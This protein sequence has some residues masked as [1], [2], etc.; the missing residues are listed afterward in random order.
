MG[1][2]GTRAWYG[3]E[4]REVRKRLRRR[5]RQQERLWLLRR[6]PD[7]IERDRNSEGWNTW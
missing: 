1:K 4:T 2:R 3:K 6:Q 5:T 7:R